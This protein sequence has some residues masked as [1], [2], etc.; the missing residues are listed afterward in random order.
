MDTFFPG[1]PTE[2]VITL[3]LLFFVV[4]LDFAFRR[5]VYDRSDPISLTLLVYSFFLIIA[6]SSLEISRSYR[7][8][9]LDVRFLSALFAY[10]T[11]AYIIFFLARTVHREFRYEQE[12]AVRNYL[13]SI[14]ATTEAPI[15]MWRS[16]EALGASMIEPDLFLRNFFKQEKRI[17]YLILVRDLTGAPIDPEVDQT[18]LLVTNLRIRLFSRVV[19]TLAFVFAL[20]SSIFF[21]VRQ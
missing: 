1:I 12:K 21:I 8:G 6:N 18:K 9:R 5:G 4:A 7:T 3:A 19:Y 16:L 17:E 14:S 13:A 10:I 2:A 20:L 11:F 15:E